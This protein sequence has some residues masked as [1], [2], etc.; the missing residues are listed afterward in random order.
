MN[1]E[2]AGRK[3]S[4]SFVIGDKIGEGALSEV[5]K[6]SSYGNFL[7]MKLYKGREHLP[8]AK[9]E[10]DLLRKLDHYNVLRIYDFSEGE[11]KFEGRPWLLLDYAPSNLEDAIKKE[12]MNNNWI[13]WYARQLLNGLEYI[14]S[15]EII[16]KDL[17]PSNLLVKNGWNMVISDFNLSS[18]CEEKDSLELSFSP[19]KISGQFSIPGGTEGWAAPEQSRGKI[20]DIDKRTDLYTAGG[21]LY[22]MMTGKMPPCREPPSSFGAP[23]WFDSFIEKAMA[24]DRDK[25]F[26]DAKSMLNQFNEGLE[27]KLE[28][29]TVFGSANKFL[30]NLVG[31]KNKM[32]RRK[33]ISY[34]G[35][36]I[37]LIAGLGLGING[38]IDTRDKENRE[39][40]ERIS[41]MLKSEDGMIAY[42][43][44]DEMTNKLYVV[45]AKNAL[46]NKIMN[47]ITF[48]EKGILDDLCWDSS[49][50]IL[51]ALRK[52]SGSDA[53]DGNCH[54]LYKVSLDTNRSE[55]IWNFD[56]K[57][58]NND[59]VV[60]KIKIGTDNNIYI[61]SKG[62]YKFDSSKNS[63]E[64]SSIV[65]AAVDDPDGKNAMYLLTQNRS[66]SEKLVIDEGNAVIK[67][68]NG[69]EAK[70][71]D[72]GE[73]KA[74]WYPPKHTK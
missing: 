22:S 59:D 47:E 68:E 2:I 11:S 65:E 5:Y 36:S 19:E 15:Q 16:H 34:L 44:A 37:V 25:R 39:K 43:E 73:I 13:K 12:K 70:F 69:D 66:R 38:C 32:S 28:T 46:E 41:Q 54:V 50:K 24:E 1:N 72:F 27:G 14:H 60:E 49:G 33:V 71:T 29:P 4:S 74:A 10:A 48:T 42:S 58:L 55:V 52:H 7:A 26:Q 18:V 8:F 23:E 35:G 53:F 9:A 40:S 6:V 20:K 64:C 61:K 17:K 45:D 51:Y 56:E 63:L 57:E 67:A 62:W 30:K 21:I 3:V 31:N